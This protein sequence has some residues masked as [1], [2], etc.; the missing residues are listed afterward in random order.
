M[1]ETHGQAPPSQENTS[2]TGMWF[3]F[4]YFFFFAE[5]TIGKQPVEICEVGWVDMKVIF[6]HC[7]TAPRH[8]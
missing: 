7:E 2:P 5:L 4:F 3:Y 1:T 8:V 6:M